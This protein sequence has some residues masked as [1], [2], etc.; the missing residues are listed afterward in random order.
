MKNIMIMMDQES[1]R[2]FK[3]YAE[4]DVRVKKFAD[5]CE[6]VYKEEMEKWGENE[7]DC[8]SACI[9]IDDNAYDVIV[10]ENV[11]PGNDISDQVREN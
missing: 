4:R 1:V 11:L 7:T 2:S 8:V 3:E 5:E 9:D 10:N 6:K